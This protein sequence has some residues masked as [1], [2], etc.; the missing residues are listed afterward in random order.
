MAHVR[1]NVKAHPLPTP[2]HRQ[3]CHPL[4]EAEVLWQRRV[5]IPLKISTCACCLSALDCTYVSLFVFVRIRDEEPDEEKLGE[6]NVLSV[7]FVCI[8]SVLDLGV[9]MGYLDQS[10]I[11][12]VIQGST[13]KN[14]YP[15]LILSLKTPTG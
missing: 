8:C 3:D 4:T 6:C 13:R 5:K 10:E 2:G 9:Q 11:P 1:R 15:D 7:T 14:P 12:G